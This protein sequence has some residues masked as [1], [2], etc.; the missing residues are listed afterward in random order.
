MQICIQSWIWS[1]HVSIAS[2]AMNLA[3]LH[4]TSSK[5]RLK[6]H[7]ASMQEY[8]KL[9][10]SVQEVFVQTQCIKTEG[11]ICIYAFLCI[12]EPWALTKMFKTVLAGIKSNTSQRWQPMIVP[13][14]MPTSLWDCPSHQM[15]HEFVSNLHLWPVSNDSMFRLRVLEGPGRLPGQKDHIH[16]DR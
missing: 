5:M 13:A 12:P 1:L 16:N 4:F 6:K 7:D 3:V 11:L 14:R 2:V 9:M 15:L 8:A 10:H